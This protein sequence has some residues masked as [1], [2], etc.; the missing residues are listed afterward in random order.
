MTPADDPR[1]YPDGR[2]L[3][4]QPPWQKDF[5]TDIP[6]DDHV[7][8]REFVK[9]LVLTSGAFAAGQC[10]I[11]AASALRE[12]GPFPRKQVAAV[13]ELE[14]KRVVEFPRWWVMEAPTGQRFCVVRPQGPE[15]ERE[16]NVWE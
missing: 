6:E 14:A 13:T 16:G 10:W 12:K 1:I 9:F 11:A 7:A 15:L 4:D 5:P 8:R 2:P 3:P